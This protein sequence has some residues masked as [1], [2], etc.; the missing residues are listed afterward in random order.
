MEG[1][2]LTLINNQSWTYWW[3]LG[4]TY[5]FYWFLFAAL[6]GAPKI[7]GN[8]LKPKPSLF[9]KSWIQPTSLY[10]IAPIYCMG[11]IIRITYSIIVQ[12]AY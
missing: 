12:T 8:N 9:L 4:G 2:S 1:N 7:S 10:R 5:P 11:S 6:E 3:A